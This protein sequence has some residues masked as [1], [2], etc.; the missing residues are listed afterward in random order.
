MRN[1]IDRFNLSMDVINRVP[2]LRVV[3]AHVKD[4]LKNQI[5]ENTNHAHEYGIDK[6]EFTNW[7][8]PY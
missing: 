6:P 3:G 7:K 2:K 8:W 1:Q 5:I 4:W